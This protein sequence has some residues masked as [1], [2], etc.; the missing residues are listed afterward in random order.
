MNYANDDYYRMYPNCFTVM[1]YNRSIIIDT[2]TRKIKYIGNNHFELIN[3]LKE[4]PIC[5]VTKLD[6]EALSLVNY[7]IENNFGQI[8]K[9]EQ[10]DNFIEIDDDVTVPF[11]SNSIIDINTININV[12][13][14]TINKLSE[15]KIA[16]IQFRFL[17][18]V[19]HQAFNQLIDLLETF[20]FYSIELLFSYPFYTSLPQDIKRSLENNL[21]IKKIF[22]FDAKK[23]NV[24][25]TSKFLFLKSPLNEYNLCGHT[26]VKYFSVFLETVINSKKYN[27]CLNC[28]IS[29]DIDGHVKNCPS[30]KES[31]GNINEVSLIEIL[32]NESFQKFNK[33]T[34][35]NIDVCKD[36]EFRY[37]C[38]DCRAY[39]DNPD[40]IYSRPSK[41]NYNPYISKWKG[42]EGYQTLEECGVITDEKEYSR[43]DEKIAAINK[44]L[45]E[46]E[47][48]ENA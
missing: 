46:E 17:K 4:K 25:H 2:N 29:V 43:D 36:C 20:S 3:K 9:E 14:N 27:S 35:D 22:V 30:M 40:N 12:L 38:S 19:K 5:D 16:N 45:W 48:A 47:E 13:N 39:T 24:K 42:E 32:N 33:I 10:L 34:K 37:V 21:M 8:L 1:G 41:C 7:L 18:D 6:T 31:Y 26:S 23:E 28:K 15:A 44:E 11:S